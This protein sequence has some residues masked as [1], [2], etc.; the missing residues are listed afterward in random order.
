MKSADAIIM[1]SPVYYAMITAETKALIERAGYVA[2]WNGKFLR[3]KIGAGFAVARRAG[4]MSTFHTLNDFFLIND[5]IVPGS[6]YWNVGIA[7]EPGEITDDEEALKIVD[8]LGDNI[9][10]LAEKLG[11]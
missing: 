11:Y 6:C 3:R 7:R 5:M 9:L 8:H 2:T 4:V 1:A 10:W